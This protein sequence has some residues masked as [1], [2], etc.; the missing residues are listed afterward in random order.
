MQKKIVSIILCLFSLSCF[1]QSKQINLEDIWENY[2]FYYKS[3][4]G[5]NSMNNG[6]F[7]TQIKNSEEGQEII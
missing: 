4:K 2:K 1:S 3:Y 5:L 6:E 7:Y